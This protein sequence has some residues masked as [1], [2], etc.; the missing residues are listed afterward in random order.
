MP[1]SHLLLSLAL[2]A[3]PAQAPAAPPSA[4]RAGT[5]AI[6]EAARLL[7]TIAAGEPDVI[8]VQR[9]AELR[10]AGSGQEAST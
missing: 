4:V 8:A 2:L 10:R 6:R 1:P 9:A 7:G 3:T 5:T